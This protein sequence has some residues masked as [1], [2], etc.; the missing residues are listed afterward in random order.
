MKQPTRYLPLVLMTLAL[1]LLACTAAPQTIAPTPGSGTPDPATPLPPAA[2]A[3]G[4]VAMAMLDFL[5]RE[6]TAE[7]DS[8]TPRP[9]REGE[10]IPDN[11]TLILWTAVKEP[12]PDDP[13][14]SL[15]REAPIRAWWQWEGNLVEAADPKAALEQHQT[16]RDTAPNT[17]AP[18]SVYIEY[19]IIHI[20]ADS[21]SARVY[22]GLFCGPLCGSGM[23]YT[24]E[25]D[26]AGQWIEQESK[27]EMNWIS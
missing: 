5:T 8:V 6:R 27:R 3:E 11:A 19:G 4:E 21:R 20:S 22:V 24:F 10:V 13:M 16:R 7:P 26:G 9:A 12:L 23:T 25:R 15:D 18:R 17:D 14:S 1:A 2:A